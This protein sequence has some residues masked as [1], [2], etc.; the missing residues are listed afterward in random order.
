LQNN[1]LQ[2]RNQLVNDNIA[3]FNSLYAIMQDVS[4]TGKVIHK[5]LSGTPER[6]ADYTIATLLKRV[7]QE[8]KAGGGENIPSQENQP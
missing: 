5:T 8:R 6:V 3:L 1:N 4:E 2:A 7:R